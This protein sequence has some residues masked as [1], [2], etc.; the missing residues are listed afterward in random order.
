MPKEKVICIEWDDA[1]WNS[2]FYDKDRPGDFTPVLTKTVGHLVKRSKTCIIV[3]QDRFYKDKKVD[4]D[5]HISVIPMK[6]VRR[7]IELKE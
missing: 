1:S 5:R 6:M 2:G 3:S 4:D 7:V